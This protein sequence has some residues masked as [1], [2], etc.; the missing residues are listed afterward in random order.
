MCIV[1][2]NTVSAEKYETLGAN[3]TTPRAVYGCG[4]CGAWLFV[5]RVPFMLNEHLKRTK[6]DK[7]RFFFAKKMKLLPDKQLFIK[8]LS[9]Y[10]SPTITV[11]RT[12][13]IW[14]ESKF[15]I[16]VSVSFWLMIWATYSFFNTFCSISMY[17]Q[18]VKFNQFTVNSQKIII[19]AISN[20]GSQWTLE[21]GPDSV[22]I[23]VNDL[24]QNITISSQEIPLAAWQLLLSQSQ[25]FVKN[26]LAWVP[27]CTE[28]QRVTM[29]MGDEVLFSVGAQDLDTSSYPMSD[30]EDIEFSWETSQMELDAVFRPGIDNPFSLTTFDNLSMVGSVEDPIVLDEEEDKENSLPPAPSTPE[31]ELSTEPPRLLRIC[32]FRNGR[33]NVP[34]SVYR[35]LFR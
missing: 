6:T 27:T 8:V 10:N 16:N 23:A 26:H 15:G 33:K 7:T 1:L 12:K 19:F 9:R 4:N 3:V 24:V 14:N 35:T 21:F 34:D 25:H 30:L 18:P 29:E 32:S 2:V 31:S 11:T 22:T 28:N 20:D 5:H 17:C 13:K